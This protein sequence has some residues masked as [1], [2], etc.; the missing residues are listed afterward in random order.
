MSQSFT[1]VINYSNYSIPTINDYNTPCKLV[2]TQIN[3]S[4]QLE[5]VNINE[6]QKSN[7][8]SI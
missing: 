3:I 7:Y 4:H 8:F 1:M 5:D 2:L 6:P